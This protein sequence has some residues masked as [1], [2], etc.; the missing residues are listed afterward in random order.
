MGWG[1]MGWNGSGSRGGR[2]VG[3]GVRTALQLASVRRSVG[4]SVLYS[5]QYL[6][7]YGVLVQYC[8]SSGNA[9]RGGRA[10]CEAEARQGKG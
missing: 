3:L 5:T 2:G 8:R 6:Y 7:F 10:A 9:W 4:A 1:W